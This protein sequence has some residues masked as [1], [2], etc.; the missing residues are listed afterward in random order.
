MAEGPQGCFLIFSSRLSM[1]V[2]F[3]SRGARLRH[4]DTMDVQKELEL[5]EGVMRF[6]LIPKVYTED[7]DSITPKDIQRNVSKTKEFDK[8]G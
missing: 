1:S 4:E 7:G 6:R 5:N 8:P 3:I 2:E